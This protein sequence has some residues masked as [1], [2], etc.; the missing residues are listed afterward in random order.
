MKAVIQHYAEAYP[1]VR[2]PKISISFSA[3]TLTNILQNFTS[4]LPEGETTNSR[5]ASSHELRQP[6]QHVRSQQNIQ[7]AGD[8][9]SQFTEINKQLIYSP[10]PAAQPVG[11]RPFAHI[12]QKALS[13]HTVQ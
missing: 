6:L 13:P 1:T 10:K 11:I 2:F 3:A 4:I 12:E 9:H 7:P 5:P 8:A